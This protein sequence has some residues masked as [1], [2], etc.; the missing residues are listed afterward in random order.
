MFRK[1]VFMK[2]TVQAK[3]WREK[4]LIEFGSKYAPKPNGCDNCWGDLHSG[5]SE[6]CK[7]EFKEYGAFWND[8]RILIS[9]T[10]AE[11]RK[12][13]IKEERERWINQ[14]ANQHDEQI[15]KVEREGLRLL[16]PSKQDPM[17]REEIL[18]KIDEVF[19]E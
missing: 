7:N 18:E 12:E 13:T 3:E 2:P 9:S 4:Q 6:K 1:E 15:R 14:P 16:L 8:L 17:S 10:L 5:C 19:K 11:A